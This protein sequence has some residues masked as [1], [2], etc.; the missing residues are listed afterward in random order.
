MRY[1]FILSIIIAFSLDNSCCAQA[2]LLKIIEIDEDGKRIELKP[3]YLIVDPNSKLELTIDSMELQ[4]IAGATFSSD[5]TA[6]LALLKKILLAEK[7]SIQNVN[8]A[9]SS[10][11]N[12]DPPS[13]YIPLLQSQSAITELILRDPEGLLIFK[14]LNSP[15]DIITQYANLFK[16]AAIMLDR[17]EQRLKDE[18]KAKGVYVQL[19]AWITNKG[20]SN[21]IHIPGF[22]S[23]SAQPASLVERYQMV[24]TPEQKEQ[25]NEISKLTSTANTEGLP[26]A[27]KSATGNA[28]HI[29][30]RLNE[31][32]SFKKADTI[33]QTIK[34]LRLNNAA[35]LSSVEQTLQETENT[36]NL[37]TGMVNGLIE[38]H[39]KPITTADHEILLLN[40]NT[41]IASLV[42]ETEALQTELVGYADKI[43]NQTGSVKTE[44]QKKVNILAT[45]L[46]TLAPALKNDIQNISKRATDIVNKLIAGNGFVQNTLD[47]TEEVKKISFDA[48]VYHATIDLQ[49][50][51]PRNLG[52]DLTIKL[53]L[54][55]AGSA[56]DVKSSSSYKL[57]FCKVYARTAVGFLFVSPTPVFKHSDGKAFFRYAPSYSI[58]LKGF[59]KSPEK[60]RESL[61]YHKTYSPGLG[62]NFSGLDFNSDGAVELGIGAVY[63][64]FQDFLQLGYGINTFDGR[65][66]A[67]FGFKVPVGAF[68]IH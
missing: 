59:W 13:K 20:E 56:P 26:Q 41:D 53:A 1:I 3:Q 39:Q 21:P 52:S 9:I 5:I 23:Y 44:L 31:M 55:K 32:K 49:T 4:K 61:S 46:K 25:L 15:P 28:G 67:F 34:Q 27:I 7:E 47:F 64:I 60:S 50:A 16:S 43:H 54:G 17:L 36:L 14:S 66:F 22:D 8:K 18:A 2:P 35:G 45:S 30:S 68:S 62:L 38:K 40:I 11:R 10:Y 37:Y 12:G 42:T 19:G 51:G 63:S 6:K 65:G 57:Y 33:Y 24:L 29:L 58:L 48:M